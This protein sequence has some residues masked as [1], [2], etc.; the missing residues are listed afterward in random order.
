MNDTERQA[1]LPYLIALLKIRGIGATYGNLLLNRFGSA[2]AVFEAPP[3][4]LR[5]LPTAIR[6]Y[7]SG[8]LKNPAV[9]QAGVDE[10]HFMQEHHIRPLV[11]GAPDYPHRLMDCPDAPQLLFA[12]GQV[13]FNAG[14]WISIVGTRRCTLYGRDS[15]SKFV[16]ELHEVVPDLG[17]VSGLALGIDVSAHKAAL[18][19]GVPTVGVLAHGLDRIYPAA[20]RDIAKQMLKQGGLLTEYPEGVWPDRGNFLARNR[21]IAGLAEATIVAESTMKGGSLVTA[22]IAF[23]YNREVFAFPGR[24]NDERSQGCNE[25]IR[26]NK[27]CLVTSAT[28]FAEEMGWVHPRTAPKVVQAQLDFEAPQPLEVAILNVLTERGE[29]TISDLTADLSIES[30]E[31]YETLLRLELCG[32]IRTY[33]GGR[34]KL[35]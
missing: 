14:H 19:C 7:L 6:N 1:D 5:L 27:A 9:L 21:I 16:Q 22:N 26:C 34:Y 15:V 31:L 8:H 12:M 25:L 35:R 11:Y 3:E 18:E 29:A 13:D 10:L 28:H 24:M 4:K 20:H 17:I 23:S 32:K 30:G 2:R 33:P